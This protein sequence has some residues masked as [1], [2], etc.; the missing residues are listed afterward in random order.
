MTGWEELEALAPGKETGRA[1]RRPPQGME[2]RHEILQDWVREEKLPGT[3]FQSG[4]LAE[5]L[6][7]ANG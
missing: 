1:D 4:S 2:G 3:V 6:Y 7:Q 5:G